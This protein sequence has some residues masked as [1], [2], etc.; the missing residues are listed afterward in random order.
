MSN[1]NDNKLNDNEL[2]YEN[3]DEL[4][5]DELPLL[6]PKDIA[7]NL[8]NHSP[9]DPCTIELLKYSKNYDPDTTSLNFEILLTIYLEGFMHILEAIKTNENKSYQDIFQNITHEDLLFPDKWFQSFSHKIVVKEYDIRD[10]N[11]N[12]NL[13]THVRKFSYCRIILQFD[14]RSEPYF[15]KKNITEKYHFIL[16]AEYKK[17]KN[18]EE[19]YALL[20][21]GKFVYKIFFKEYR[22]KKFETFKT[23]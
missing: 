10:E 21:K 9:K 7:T 23:L 14:N 18:I 19:I 5:I 13:N 15:Q 3:Y 17:T 4:N 20:T 2:N 16:N 6:M 22:V 12:N 1:L 11:D 8:F